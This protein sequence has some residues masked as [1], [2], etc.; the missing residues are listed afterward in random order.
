MFFCLIIVEELVVW[1]ILVVV[2][3]LEF[4]KLSEIIFI[5]CSEWSEFDD[6]IVEFELLRLVKYFDFL[7]KVFDI[8]INFLRYWFVLLVFFM[9]SVW[10]VWRDIL[11]MVFFVVEML[12]LVEIFLSL[13]FFREGVVIFN[14]IWVFFL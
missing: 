11:Y 9:F 14:F 4:L 7:F 5:E 6:F 13:F 12:L 8:R 1:G 3:F 2:M 10:L